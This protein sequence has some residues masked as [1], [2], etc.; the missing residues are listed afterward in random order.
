V[1]VTTDS[2]PD[3]EIRGQL[4]PIFMSPATKRTTWGAIRAGHRQAP[5]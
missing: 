1:V 2:F 4:T 5:K 3:G